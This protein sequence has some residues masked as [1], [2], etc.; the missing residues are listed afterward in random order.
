ML[1]FMARHAAEDVLVNVFKPIKCG[2][3][4]SQ[5]V[6]TAGIATPVCDCSDDHWPRGKG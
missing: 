5:D 1:F 6:Q 2:I 3:F 4:I